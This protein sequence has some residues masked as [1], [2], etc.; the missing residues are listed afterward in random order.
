[1]LHN[2]LYV[3]EN[4]EDDLLRSKRVVLKAVYYYSY[5]YYLIIIII[6]INYCYAT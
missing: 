6:T 3:K 5:N 1:M 4:P 2:N